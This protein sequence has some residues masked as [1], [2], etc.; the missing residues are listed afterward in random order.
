MAAWSQLTAQC[1]ASFSVRFRSVALNAMLPHEKFYIV[2]GSGGI[3][4]AKVRRPRPGWRGCMF[5][6]GDIWFVTHFAPKQGLNHAQE[7]SIAQSAKAEHLAKKK[8]PVE[9]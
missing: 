9:K 6:D 2:R 4:Y 7:I 3:G 1:R 8:K 5:R